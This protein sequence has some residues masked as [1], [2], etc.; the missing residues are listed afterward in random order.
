MSLNRKMQG[1][2]DP[3]KESR[4]NSDME[5]LLVSSVRYEPTVYYS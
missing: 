2:G 4:T 3:G 5:S 1:G